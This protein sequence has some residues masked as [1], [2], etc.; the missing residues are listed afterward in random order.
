MSILFNSN[1]IPDFLTGPI[2]PTGP[3]GV[4]GAIGPTGPTGD[5]GPIGP[6]GPTGVAGADGAG[7]TGGNYD[8]NTGIVSFTSNDG[9]GFST[10]DIRGTGGTTTAPSSPSFN[11]LRFII[12]SDN[13]A[14][15]S[16]WGGIAYNARWGYFQSNFLDPDFANYST[17][18]YTLSATKL[19]VKKAGFYM[20]GYNMYYRCD[21][22]NRAS[23]KNSLYIVSNNVSKYQCISQN[24]MRNNNSNDTRYSTNNATQILYLTANSEI[25]MVF[26]QNAYAGQITL[27]NSST[28]PSDIFIYRLG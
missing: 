11:G 12:T 10:T 1:P 20:V 17:D 23:I 25:R 2:G 18:D 3:T 7:F 24:Y 15:N 9:L 22:G 28:S 21:F 19:F 8:E 27:D 26:Q 13:S 4:A 5:T 16:Y 14:V 6:T